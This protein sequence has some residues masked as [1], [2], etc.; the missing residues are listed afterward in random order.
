MNLPIPETRSGWLAS[1]LLMVTLFVVYY[2]G[3]YQLNLDYYQSQYTRVSF[4]NFLIS[5]CSSSVQQS[6][7]P[8]NF[9]SAD[10][11]TPTSMSEIDIALTAL[12]LPSD[13][14]NCK[15]ARW[16]LMLKIPNY[17]SYA[18]PGWIYFEL[19]NEEDVNG[20]VVA[21]GQ[22]VMLGINL[23]GEKLN[24]LPSMYE[25]D[26]FIRVVEQGNILPGMSLYGRIY[27]GGNQIIDAKECDKAIKRAFYVNGVLI[28]T[29]VEGN[30]T[31]P[32]N[33]VTRSLSR[34]VV[35]NILLPPWTNVLLPA[36]S[37]LA[38]YLFEKVSRSNDDMDVSG[39]GFIFT[40]IKTYIYSLASVMTTGVLLERSLLSKVDSPE[41][42]A[43]QEYIAFFVQTAN[44]ILV[45]ICVFIVIALAPKIKLIWR[46]RFQIHAGANSHLK[47]LYTICENIIQRIKKWVGR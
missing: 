18:A 34:S 4:P 5:T 47:P 1:L 44:I 29:Q 6:G 31:C 3:I 42:Y 24:L 45:V 14:E 21:K 2:Q 15:T 43:N 7:V 9:I 11:L 10:T 22:D 26:I 19:K 39:V 41:E 13:E 32:Q 25:D 30:L 16:S 36:L 33:D 17:I 40:T 27:F 8:S 20:G 38:C 37:L 46:G 23:S 35:E 12:P 28:D